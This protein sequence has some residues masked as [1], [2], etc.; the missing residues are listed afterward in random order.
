MLLSSQPQ[1]K[2]SLLDLFL[3]RLLLLFVHHS[4]TVGNYPISTFTLLFP[5]LHTMAEDHNEGVSNTPLD[6]LINAIAGNHYPIPHDHTHEHDHDHDVSLD[7]L[8][9]QRKDS[10]EDSQQHAVRD[11]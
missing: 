11:L 2:S 1:L 10:A 8:L 3:R 9:S 4:N 6:L 7:H 5:P